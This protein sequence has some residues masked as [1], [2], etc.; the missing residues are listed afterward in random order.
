MPEF[1]ILKDETFVD[2]AKAVAGV[3]LTDER[4]DDERRFI[5]KWV[6][7]ILRSY[8]YLGT[9]ELT[10]DFQSL[11][12]AATK[13]A[14]VKAVTDRTQNFY[15]WRPETKTV[16]GV[17]RASEA[18]SGRGVVPQT[19]SRPRLWQEKFKQ[20]VR[21]APPMPDPYTRGVENFFKVMRGG[22]EAAMRGV[23]LQVPMP[24]LIIAGVIVAGLIFESRIR[25]V[26]GK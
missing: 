24:V 25:G 16:L 15:S 10:P 6:E 12:D 7:K 8:F 22:V 18:L 5:P 9:H 13:A 19:V 23:G 1:L 4:A 14:I 17:L 26:I 3:Q 20:Q 2:A 11:L 21:E